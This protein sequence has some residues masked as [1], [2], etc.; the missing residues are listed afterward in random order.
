MRPEAARGQ[1][2]KHLRSLM[3]ETFSSDMS[4]TRTARVTFRPPLCRNVLF[5]RSTS[6]HTIHIYCYVFKVPDT[7][8]T[9]TLTDVMDRRLR[10]TQTTALKFSGEPTSKLLSASDTLHLD[11][12]SSLPVKTNELNYRENLL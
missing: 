7:R 5:L 2:V 6:R 1:K 8:V 3:Q 9:V 10:Q 11:L 4:G 12:F